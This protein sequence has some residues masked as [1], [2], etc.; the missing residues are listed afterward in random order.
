M[1]HINHIVSIT[2]LLLICVAQPDHMSSMLE[3]RDQAHSESVYPEDI[4]LEYD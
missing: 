2:E 1:D 3:F 4:L